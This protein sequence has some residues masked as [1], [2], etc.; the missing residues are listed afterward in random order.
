MA[1]ETNVQEDKTSLGMSDEDFLK[2]AN[3]PEQEALFLED[4]QEDK[5]DSE[6]EDEDTDDNKSESENEDDDD[7]D[8]EDDT[9]SE[10]KDET[11]TDEQ[12]T[13]DDDE[14]SEKNTSKTDGETEDDD[15]ETTEEDSAENAEDS[16]DQIDYKAE[17]EKLTAPFKANDRQ[18]QVNN[19]ED[20]LTLMRM[21]ANYHK[22]MAGLKPSL[23]VVKLL[24]KNGLL[25]P[26]K[27]NYLIDL[28]TKKPEAITKLIKESGVNPLEIDV[29]A[30][31]NYVPENRAVSDQEVD[32]DNVLESIKSTPTYS[33]TI[34]VITEQWDDQSRELIAD[35]PQIIEVINGHMANGTYDVIADVV[36]RERSL[37]R[38]QGHSDLAAYKAV[39][40]MLHSQN[41]LPGQVP[42]KKTPKNNGKPTSNVSKAEQKK[43]KK[44]V[45]TT[46]ASKNKSSGKAD[47]NPLALS[48]EEF[49]KIS[50]TQFT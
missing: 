2:V 29:T 38:L 27:I 19:V 48:D 33:K 18:M 42:P 24:E 35:T 43:R 25:D 44:A 13:D 40:E 4:E 46:K 20:A 17:Y 10:N 50:E 23:K 37:G 12:D 30:D 34:N 41:L 7:V 45:S 31:D 28:H 1:E 11:D 8:S 36:T 5:N 16:T 26:D 32:L 21:G 9:D 3:D 15:S 14:T 47:F 22:K 39:G 49:T 6:F